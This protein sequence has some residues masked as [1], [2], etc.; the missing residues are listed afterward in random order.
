MLDAELD[1]MHVCQ[2]LVEFMLQGRLVAWVIARPKP[3]GCLAL[4]GGVVDD[5]HAPEG[6]HAAEVGGKL[7]GMHL[8]GVDDAKRRLVAPPDSVNLWPASALWKNSLP[9]A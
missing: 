4:L 7:A 6:Y 8:V 2:P 5:A 3:P 1:D 9:S